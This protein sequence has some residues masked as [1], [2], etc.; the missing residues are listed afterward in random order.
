MVAIAFKKSG[1]LS[2]ADDLFEGLNIG[3][4]PAESPAPEV[5]LSP[6]DETHADFPTVGTTVP[7]RPPQHMTSGNEPLD[8]ATVP[9][10]QVAG[11]QALTPAQLVEIAQARQHKDLTDFDTSLAQTVGGKRSITLPRDLLDQRSRGVTSLANMD[12]HVNPL[13]VQ[14]V[15]LG[16][17]GEPE[18]FGK[19]VLVHHVAPHITRNEQD[20][21]LEWNAGRPDGLQLG[22]LPKSIAQ[23]NAA[24]NA[25]ETAEKT[26]AVDESGA[27]HAHQMGADGAIV[28]MKSEDRYSDWDIAPEDLRDNGVVTTGGFAFHTGILAGGNMQS[29]DRLRSRAGVRDQ[30]VTFQRSVHVTPMLTEAQL[31]ILAEITDAER[32]ESAERFKLLL[33][34]PAEKIAI[35]KKIQN[36]KVEKQTL[37][38]KLEKT[39]NID[40][41]SYGFRYIFPAQNDFGGFSMLPPVTDD[42]TASLGLQVRSTLTTERG[43]LARSLGILNDPTKK[44]EYAGIAANATVQTGHGSSDF[45]GITSPRALIHT[46]VDANTGL[47]P[48][49]IS[50]PLANLS[51]VLPVVRMRFQGSLH[52]VAAGTVVPAPVLAQADGRILDAPTG[53][54]HA[55]VS[56]SANGLPLFDVA[57]YAL[58]DTQKGH[59]EVLTYLQKKYQR[60]ISDKRVKWTDDD[61]ARLV[62]EQKKFQERVVSDKAKGAIPGFN[63]SPDGGPS[64]GSGVLS[65]D[66]IGTI[67]LKTDFEKQPLVFDPLKSWNSVEMVAFQPSAQETIAGRESAFYGV[68]DIRGMDPAVHGTDLGTGKRPLTEQQLSQEALAEAAFRVSVVGQGLAGFQLFIH[69]PDQRVVGHH[70]VAYAPERLDYGLSAKAPHVA[71]PVLT[72]IATKANH[73]L[74][75]AVSTMGVFND[76]YEYKTREVGQRVE[77]VVKR[78]Q[79]PFGIHHDI[80]L[81][82]PVYEEKNGV[83]V[84]V[85]GASRQTYA[86]SYIS[87]TI[88]N[89]QKDDPE[90][91]R[92]GLRWFVP[93]SD[94]A[95]ST[96]EG[97]IPLRTDSDGKP[98]PTEDDSAAWVRKVLS[99]NATTGEVTSSWAVRGDKSGVRR[100]RGAN[101][102]ISHYTY[103]GPA[104]INA[105]V[106]RSGNENDDTATEKTRAR[107]ISELRYAQ[108]RGSGLFAS[109]SYEIIPLIA[110]DYVVPGVKAQEDQAYPLPWHRALGKEI[111]Q[112]IFEIIPSPD[113]TLTE[114]QQLAIRQKIIEKMAQDFFFNETDPRKKGTDAET[115]D[116]GNSSQ[117]RKDK[118][119]NQEIYA[120]AQLINQGIDTQDF[121]RMIREAKALG[122]QE[123]Y[124]RQRRAVYGENSSKQWIGQTPIIPRTP[125]SRQILVGGYR[126]FRSDPQALD[127]VE[128]QGQNMITLPINNNI[129]SGQSLSANTGL[130]K[131]EFLESL[132]SKHDIDP[133]FITSVKHDL[134][135]RTTTCTL[136][137]SI[138]EYYKEAGIS[139]EDAMQIATK[140][141]GFSVQQHELHPVLPSDFTPYDG[142]IEQ[143]GEGFKRGFLASLSVIKPTRDQQGALDSKGKILQDILKYFHGVATKREVNDNSQ[144]L[145]RKIGIPVDAQDSHYLFASMNPDHYEWAT[146]S[147]KKTIDLSSPEYASALAILDKMPVKNDDGSPD[148]DA[149]GNKEHR[150]R[151]LETIKAIYQNPQ[152][153]EQAIVEW[154][155]P[156]VS[157]AIDAFPNI[158]QRV[159]DESE[160]YSLP[161]QAGIKVKSAD[162]KIQET[163]LLSQIPWDDQEHKIIIKTRTGEEREYTAA[164]YLSGLFGGKTIAFSGELSYEV[165]DPLNPDEKTSA[166]LTLYAF[167]PDNLNKK[168]KETYADI[169]TP[170]F[171]KKIGIHA[172]HEFAS[173]YATFDENHPAVASLGYGGEGSKNPFT[174]LK[175]KINSFLMSSD[176]ETKARLAGE[177]QNITQDFAA[178]QMKLVYDRIKFFQELSDEQKAM[179]ISLKNQSINGN[180]NKIT[181]AFP[182]FEVGESAQLQDAR[183]AF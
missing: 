118:V 32:R 182:D 38:N 128:F 136:A 138:V 181:E 142:Y 82:E 28:P 90:A 123:E 16:D 8:M 141:N 76:L 75:E 20:G 157:A 146:L 180:F 26:Y 71:G 35:E 87:S 52:F 59:S 167:N 44:R 47:F 121:N 81:Y 42:S 106:R 119:R 85:P 139:E 99:Q 93:S 135:K 62:A 163:R 179:F 173:S 102:Q 83:W 98:L 153:Q 48:G 40:Q 4:P 169:A 166:P 63:F 147:G 68:M 9:R 18:I 144:G 168:I 11:F 14:R 152:A 21:T 151:L 55:R 140:A 165:E 164:S 131:S 124:K 107:K 117:A 56:F 148:I 33:A 172:M 77:S 109:A 17:D 50:L 64:I 86:F 104:V 96:G 170:E 1:A 177:I 108:R 46:G 43:Y 74:S 5:T 162:G 176:E 155:K 60:S 110:Y 158:L 178:K 2:R 72:S 13:S 10:D 73:D 122:A 24:L 58:T 114:Q 94:L 95:F 160:S 49:R 88:P 45:F 34:S 145:L 171:M 120:A 175:K 127:G 22:V 36:I 91:K 57:G 7:V 19:H 79:E 51:S 23:P 105:P 103:V 61:Q 29:P 97:Y 130:F 159:K 3:T 113:E 112:A 67:D 133:L 129:H 27:V 12:E 69:T 92:A 183:D 150:H 39:R 156:K 30:P 154:A 134:D 100:V 111:A 6:S 161:A 116:A 53:P 126:L 89:I 65:K 143:K 78:A 41:Q 132:K 101:T 115:D 54:R 137:R 149:E 31:P 70:L 66:P 84:E 174:L 25:R 37:R 80:P 15:V 125:V